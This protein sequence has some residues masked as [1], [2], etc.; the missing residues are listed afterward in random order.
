MNKVPC[1]PELTMIV[2]F[3]PPYG[4]HTAY[5]ED[6]GWVPLETIRRW[7]GAEAIFSGSDDIR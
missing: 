3:L 4:V 2:P 1:V 7:P 6:V 5:G